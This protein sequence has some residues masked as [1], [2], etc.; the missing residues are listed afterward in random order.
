M[1]STR[2][3]SPSPSL[4]TAT[5]AAGDDALLSPGDLDVAAAGP[6]LLTFV[7]GG[8]LHGC[9]VEGLREIVT[10]RATTRLPG[11]PPFVLGLLNLRGTLVTVLDVAARLD[12]T[13]AASTDGHVIVL[14]VEGR[15]AGCRVDAVRRVRP[16][17]PLD[18]PP[19]VGNPEDRGVVMGIGEVDGESVVVLDLSQLV[20]QTL[21][22]PGER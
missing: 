22:F 11:A 1:A 14:E 12:A 10:T 17:P 19:A 5:D 7:L 4:P 9:P 16:R 21:L 6:Q 8:R 2:T 20:R 18:P 3:N 13:R 15:L